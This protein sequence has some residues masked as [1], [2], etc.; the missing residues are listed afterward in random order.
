MVWEFQALCEK[1]G[2]TPS[3][4]FVE[5]NAPTYER[6]GLRTL[7]I[8]EEALLHLKTMSLAG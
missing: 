8:A 3:C 5:G 4:S 6:A 7:K 1:N 2:L